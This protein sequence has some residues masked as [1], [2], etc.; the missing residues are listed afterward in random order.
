MNPTNLKNGKPS[1]V[2]SHGKE[3]LLYLFAFITVSLSSGLI[4]GYP[5]LRNNLLANGSDLTESELGIMYTVGSWTQGGRFFSGL[6]RDRFGTRYVAFFSLLSA[7]CGCLGLAFANKNH[8]IALSLSYFFVGLGAGGQLC[9]QPVAGL[10]PKEWQG[11]ILASL[12]GA[13]QISGLVFLVLIQLTHNRKLSYGFFALLLFVISLCCLYLLPKDQFMNQKKLLSV[14]QVDIVEDDDHNHAK[15][16]DP[17]T[18]P[19]PSTQTTKQYDL[20]ETKAI[21]LIKSMEYISLLLWFTIML[22]PLQHYIG[23]IAFQ[24]ERKG[25]DG[26]YINLFSIF[27]ASSAVFAPAVGKIA[28]VAGLGVT[29]MIATILTTVSL[30]LLN[31]FSLRIQVA[32]M[33]CYGIGRLTVFAMYFT[34]IGKRFG[35]THYGTLAG[36]GLLI[37]AFFALLQYPLIDAAANGHES[38]VNLISGCVLLG[39]GVPY[40]IWLGMKERKEKT[41][42]K[43]KKGEHEEV[44]PKDVI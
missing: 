9:L 37:S 21:E 6:A 30:I 2:Q 18:P 20:N 26:Q 39:S 25:D 7:V 35:Y 17:S 5:H 36:L 23:T 28:D 33:A 24:L 27:Y 3:L 10:F 1:L 41:S 43:N 14:H 29:Q 8:I 38:I 13:F 44:L 15:E 32:G 11:T 42:H 34:N 31:S 4:F 22:I 19:S 40:C 16:D 12:S